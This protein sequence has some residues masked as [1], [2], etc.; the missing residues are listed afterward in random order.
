MAQE[1]EQEY[2]NKK[3][4]ANSI[5]NT[6]SRMGEYKKQQIIMTDRELSSFQGS[7]LRWRD[8]VWTMS[9]IDR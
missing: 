6:R 1:P 2:T 4:K 8:T 7:T 5:K 3:I 9:T